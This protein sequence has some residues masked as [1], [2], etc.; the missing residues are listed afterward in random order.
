MILLWV[1]YAYRM[2]LLLQD[3]VLCGSRDI[4]VYDCVIAVI[5]YRHL[6]RRPADVSVESQ[7]NGIIQIN[8]FK[9]STRHGIL[10]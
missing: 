2:R 1:C 9:A 7:S 4:S 6:D 3:I 5:S 8:S 10:L